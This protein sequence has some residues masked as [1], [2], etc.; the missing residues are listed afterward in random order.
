MTQLVSNIVQAIKGIP[1]PSVRVVAKRSREVNTLNVA[2]TSISHG[3]RM[4]RFVIKKLTEQFLRKEMS[5]EHDQRYISDPQRK[6]FYEPRQII[7]PVTIGLRI[8]HASSL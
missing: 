2:E 4:P 6:M 5:F 8:C 3:G 7:E 1:H